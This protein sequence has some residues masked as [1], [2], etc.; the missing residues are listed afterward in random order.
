MAEIEHLTDVH[1]TSIEDKCQ[2]LEVLFMETRS[3]MEA[4][5]K[6]EDIKT[7]LSQLEYRQHVL[8]SEVNAILATPA[9]AP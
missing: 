5:P 2:T 1:R 8:E 9:P 4:K 3:E 7:T 6:H